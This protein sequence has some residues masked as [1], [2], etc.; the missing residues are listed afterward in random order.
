VRASGEI[1]ASE[2]AAEAEGSDEGEG[3]VG[4]AIGGAVE[5]ELPTHA[6]VRDG[7]IE[8]EVEVHEQGQRDVNVESESEGEAGLRDPRCTNAG[9]TRAPC[10]CV[11]STVGSRPCRALGGRW[12]VAHLQRID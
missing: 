2:G 12:Q 4:A 7:A 6:L 3:V 1:T 9:A 5:H 10:A 11:W 8:L